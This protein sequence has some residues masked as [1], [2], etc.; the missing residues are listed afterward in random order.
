MQDVFDAVSDK[1][2]SERLLWH[3]I[4]PLPIGHE[5]I[6]RQWLGEVSD[7]WLQVK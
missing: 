1:V 4:H 3:A 6:A 5:L 2:V 7:R